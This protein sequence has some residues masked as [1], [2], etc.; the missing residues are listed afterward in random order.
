MLI[1]RDPESWQDLQELTAKLFMEMGCM[2]EVEKGVATARGSVEIDVYVQDPTYIPPLIL[3]CECKYWSKRIPKHVVHAFRTVVSDLG[4]NTGYVISKAGFQ[5]GAIEAAKNSNVVLL[6]WTRFQEIF[7]T[8][9]VRSMTQKLYRYADII[10]D[11]MDVLDDRMQDIEWT[12]ESRSKHWNLMNRSALYIHANQWS[13]ARDYSHTFPM[14]VNSPRNEDDEIVT[15]R[16]YREYF[17]LAFSAAV[18]L[19]S[20]WRDFFGENRAYNIVDCPQDN[21]QPSEDDFN[22]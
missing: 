15:L 14:T 7:C 11:Y 21:Q 16:S 3:L 12:T 22:E 19:I 9:W 5:G 6:G 8:R 20:D 10:F 1:E 2:P 4:A 17:D 18:P 13:V